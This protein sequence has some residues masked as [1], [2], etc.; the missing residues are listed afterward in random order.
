VDDGTIANT[1]L[2]SDIINFTTYN[3]AETAPSNWELTSIVC[4]VSSPFGG[5]QTV[6]LPSVAIDLREGENVTCTFT[7]SGQDFGDAPDTGAGTSQ[8][9]YNTVFTDNGPYHLIIP[10]LKLGAVAPDVDPGTLQNATAD[11]DDLT[12]TD[13][14]DGVTTMPSV[15]IKST[16][17]NLS[18]NVFNNT[19]SQASLA[20]WMDFNRDG[21]F[22][23]VGEKSVPITVPASMGLRTY[24]QFFSGFAPP[25]PGS[26][27]LRCRLA[28][29][30]TQIQNATGAA[31]S[32]EVEDYN[33]DI[34]QIEP[35]PPGT[36]NNGGPARR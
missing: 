10:N 6:T 7:N 32:G 36:P 9:N 11:A 1:K 14:E 16:S 28:W 18:V 21:D 23:D 35:P 30:G 15:N 24:G 31:Q 13:D 22:T 4:T 2:F 20:C 29:N 17:V 5:S 26:S 3:V 27:V 25:I 8:G 12:A 33:V 19:G 34:A